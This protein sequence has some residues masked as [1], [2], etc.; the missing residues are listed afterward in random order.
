M[1]KLCWKSCD[2]GSNVR[3]A[4]GAGG[5]FDT[6]CLFSTIDADTGNGGGGGGGSIWVS[7]LS[8]YTK[9][10]SFIWPINNKF[11]WYK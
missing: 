6:Y 8:F 7:I 4:G 9:P 11:Q 2:F 10:F 1:L 3:G 5:S